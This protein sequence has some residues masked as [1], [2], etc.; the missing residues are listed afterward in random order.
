MGQ[1]DGIGMVH[2]IK[3]GCEQLLGQPPAGIGG[4][5]PR[6]VDLLVQVEV[7]GEGEER[8]P[9]SVECGLQG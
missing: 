9:Q 1:R 8:G 5:N 4:G 6:L 7:D 2:I 3:E